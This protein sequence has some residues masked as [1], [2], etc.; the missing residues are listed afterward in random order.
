MFRLA[1]RNEE[2]STVEAPTSPCCQRQV[3]HD[4]TYYFDYAF[5]GFISICMFSTTSNAKQTLD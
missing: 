2:L 5:S 3:A 4:F 1:E